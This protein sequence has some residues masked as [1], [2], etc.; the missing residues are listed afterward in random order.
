[1][2]SA[3]ACPEKTIR[4]QPTICPLIYNGRQYMPRRLNLKGATSGDIPCNQI[5][6]ELVR[7]LNRYVNLIENLSKATG[8]TSSKC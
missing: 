2:M 6:Q 5:G 1:M 4:G 7:F 3:H 8:L